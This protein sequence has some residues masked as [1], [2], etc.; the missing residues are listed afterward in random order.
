MNDEEKQKYLKEI[1]LTT[2]NQVY[3]SKKIN[4][5]ELLSQLTEELKEIVKGNDLKVNSK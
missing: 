2:H 1:L 4:V 5:N 3:S